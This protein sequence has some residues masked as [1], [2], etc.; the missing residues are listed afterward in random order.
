MDV[1]RYDSD[2]LYLT[3]ISVLP[4]MGKS[5]RTKLPGLLEKLKYTAL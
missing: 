4:F 3:R 1:N 2:L 5:L